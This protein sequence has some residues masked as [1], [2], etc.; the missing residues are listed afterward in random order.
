MKTT[1]CDGSLFFSIFIIIF[2]IIMFIIIIVIVVVAVLHTFAAWK[3]R[4]H[5]KV[6][7][8]E[9]GTLWSDNADV[10]G[11]VAEK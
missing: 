8:P 4:T 1:S 2:I 6:V 11:N 7:D 3:Y 9:I 5:D 10:H